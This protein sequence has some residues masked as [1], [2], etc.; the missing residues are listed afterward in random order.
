MADKTG[1]SQQ[2]QASKGALRRSDIQ[3]LLEDNSAEIRKALPKHLTLERMTKVM[4]LCIDRVPDLLKCTTRSLVS[5]LMQ[6]AELGLEPGGIR[7]LAYLIPY[8]VGGQDLGRNCTLI[9][10]YKGL[11]QLSL[12]SRHLQQIEARVV[13]ANDLFQYEFGLA[14]RL[15]H[16]PALDKAPGEPIAVYCVAR[17]RNGQTHVELM[18]WREVMAVKARSRSSGDGPWVTDEE[19][20]A[21]KTAI[22]RISNYVELS[23][24]AMTALEYLGDQPEAPVELEV[25]AP[26]P[27]PKAKAPSLPE[28]GQVETIPQAIPQSEVRSTSVVTPLPEAANQV[29]PAEVAREQVR[30]Q[31]ETAMT[32]E[33][34]KGNGPGLPAPGTAE[35]ADWLVSS[36]RAATTPAE[37][38]AL[39]EHVKKVPAARKAQVD[40]EYRAAKANLKGGGQ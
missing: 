34:K 32:E 1:V 33:A 7:G 3:A 19:Q 24:E 25:T 26:P 10:G 15:R 38:Q 21:R 20:M 2:I 36:I 6:C 22:R 8:K 4:L 9:V 11:I 17:L 40:A 35:F 30:R 12:R 39:S 37:L 27:P 14:P 13:H 16:V 23:P 28:D 31:A 5:C 18:T 29:D